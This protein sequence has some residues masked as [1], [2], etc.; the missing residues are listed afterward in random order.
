MEKSDFADKFEGFVQTVNQVWNDGVF[1]IDIG[2]FLVAGGIIVFFILF[3]KILYKFMIKRIQ[4]FAA[5]TDNKIDDEI[6]SALQR[7][8]SFVPVVFGFY[9]AAE[10]LNMNGTTGLITKNFIHSSIVFVLFW[11][12]FN[13][14]EA[15]AWVLEKLESVFDRSLIEWLKKLIK[16]TFI[17]IGFATILEIWGI[18]IG[19]IIAGLGLFGV[20]V[21]LGAQDLFK[22]LISGI[23]I[24]A[25]NR[26]SIGDWVRVEGV[27]EGTVE[28]IGFRSTKIRRF[29]KAPVF[30]PNSR[31]SDNSVIN[32]SEMTFR[33]I[34]WMIALRYD[35]TI[36]QLKAVRNGIEAFLLENDD[37]V[38]PPLAPLFVRVDNF[39]NSSIDLMIYCFTKTTI[40][41]EWLEIKEGLALEVKKIVEKSGTDFAFPSRSVYIEKDDTNSTQPLL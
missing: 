13:L 28:S 27:V 11:S 35:S 3:R 22:N 16:G 5:K 30:V 41:K 18:R 12:F 14:V 33:R 31:L 9:I 26:F 2:S 32:F 19:P 39:N 10:Y 25:E 36:D 23:L 4:N 6:V 20:A 21:A 1:G 34:S 37:F 38:N 29:D 8:V 24:L 17:F 7:P 15:F 40:W